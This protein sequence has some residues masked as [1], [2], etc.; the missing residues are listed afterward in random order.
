MINLIWSVIVILFVLWLAG[1]LFSIGGA[2]I[3]II[4]VVALA[5]LVFN[6]ITKGR[7]TI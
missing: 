7:A 4:L 2:F 1:L 6:I 5:L 3:H